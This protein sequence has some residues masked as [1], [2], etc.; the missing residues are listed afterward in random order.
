MESPPSELLK[1]ELDR[2]QNSSKLEHFLTEGSGAFK[3]S[4]PTLFILW[5]FDYNQYSH[6]HTSLEKAVDF[7]K[8]VVL[9]N[10]N[11]RKTK[12]QVL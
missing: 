3:R 7:L 4:L 12:H 9:E 8:P 6:K 10:S 1:A 11:L 5:Q 2:A